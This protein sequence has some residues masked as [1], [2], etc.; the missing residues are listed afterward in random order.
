MPSPKFQSIQNNST[1]PKAGWA[2]LMKKLRDRH[3]A[4]WTSWNDGDQH[5]IFFH[6]LPQWAEGRKET[7]YYTALVPTW[8]LM[9]SPVMRR[10]LSWWVGWLLS[11]IIT[12]FT[13][14]LSCNTTTSEHH[15]AHNQQLLLMRRTET[16]MSNKLS[17]TCS[18]NRLKTTLHVRCRYTTR[19]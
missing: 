11:W 12:I 14:A 1:G 19:Q 6:G 16:S 10:G 4:W 15:I 3:K 9:A 5:Y 7:R 8:H 13:P 2:G 18:R 17:L